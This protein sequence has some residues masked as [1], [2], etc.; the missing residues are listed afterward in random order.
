MRLYTYFRSS[1][2]YRV[3]IALNLKGLA[4]ESSP[5]NLLKGDQSR[6]EYLALNT[7]GRVPALVVEGTSL[8]QSPAILEYLEET[9][10]TP[11]LLPSSPVARAQVRA[12]CALIACDIHPLNNI[13]VLRYLKRQLGQDQPT[14]DTWYKHWVEEGFAALEHLL[15]PSP[16]AFGEQ[17]TLADVYL[18]PQI[19]NARRL[20]VSL[21]AYP[22]IAGIDAT[23]AKIPAFSNAAPERQPDAI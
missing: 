4:Y 8:I 12:A 17:A 1:A 11:P 7:Q 3:R 18:V 21:E 16:F 15:R 2:A 10:P 14:I 9:Y 22:K 19:Y 6:S 23:C 5:V 13:G 20:N